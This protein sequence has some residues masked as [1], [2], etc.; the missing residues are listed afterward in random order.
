MCISCSNASPVRCI[1]RPSSLQF[2]GSR[3]DTNITVDVTWLNVADRITFEIFLTENFASFK[4]FEIS[5]DSITSSSKQT[6][7]ISGNYLVRNN[8]NFIRYT[9]RHMT[10]ISLESSVLALEYHIVPKIM[11]TTPK[12]LLASSDE[13]LPC[14]YRSCFR[15]L[16]AST[17]DCVPFHQL[18]N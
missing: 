3:E 6:I 4:V 5:D 8:I 7:T 17:I 13:S 11:H 9:V 2:V 14:N 10:L 12:N 15:V 18:H 1:P 16:V